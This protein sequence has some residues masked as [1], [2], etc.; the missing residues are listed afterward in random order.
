M[1]THTVQLSDQSVKVD[2][3]YSRLVYL[4]ILLWDVLMSI[5]AMITGRSRRGG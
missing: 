5:A 3:R 1:S 2:D 4:V